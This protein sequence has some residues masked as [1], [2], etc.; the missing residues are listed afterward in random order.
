MLTKEDIIEKLNIAALDSEFQDAVIK[1]YRK[2]NIK[3]I[4]QV[5]KKVRTEVVTNLIR[6][7]NYSKLEM[8]EMAVKC[9]NISSGRFRKLFKKVQLKMETA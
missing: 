8:E 5:R 7:A 9:C 3:S 2:N 1:T 4:Q 6:M